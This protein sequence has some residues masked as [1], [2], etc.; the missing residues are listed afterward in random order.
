MISMS[1][2]NKI[3]GIYCRE[4]GVSLKTGFSYKGYCV[5]CAESVVKD[6]IDEETVL[7]ES[8][9]NRHLGADGDETTE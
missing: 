3:D 6:E 2:D 5:V 4:C 7:L 9:I 1:S 8:E